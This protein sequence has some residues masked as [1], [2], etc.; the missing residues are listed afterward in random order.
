MPPLILCYK[1]TTKWFYIKCDIQSL[2]KG[3]RKNSLIC[4]VTFTCLSTWYE[5][6]T[7]RKT[8]AALGGKAYPYSYSYVYRDATMGAVT[9]LN[10]GLESPC[11][12]HIFGQAINPSW[13]LVGGADGKIN[14]TIPRGNKLVIDSSPSS[15]EISEYTTQNVFIKNLYQYSDFST[16]R[17]ITI[18]KG[19]QTISFSHDG[20][21]MLEAYVEVKLLAETV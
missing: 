14:Y 7:V 5:E 19:E 21:T 16:A 8:T 18:P 2:G 3:E 10:N 20:I 13:T 15:L 11:R 9:I 17:F 4:P 12:I 1:P 6:A